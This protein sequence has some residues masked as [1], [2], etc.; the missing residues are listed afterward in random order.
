MWRL[1]SNTYFIRNS[2]WKFWEVKSKRGALILVDKWFPRLS[3]F[4]L[5]YFWSWS[6]FF[7][8]YSGWLWP[9]YDQV[10]IGCKNSN[11]TSKNIWPHIEKYRCGFLKQNGKLSSASKT[12]PADIWSLMCKLNEKKYTSTTWQQSL[13]Y[14]TGSLKSK[15]NYDFD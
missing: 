2:F 12:K 1:W 13:C 4:M 14:S 6:W 10:R 7:Q 11:A 15:N 8:F 5:W 3:A 9:C